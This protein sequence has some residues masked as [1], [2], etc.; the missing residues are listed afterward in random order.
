[1]PNR[2]PEAVRQR[3]RDLHRAVI[4]INDSLHVASVTIR[5]ESFALKSA[6][7]RIQQ[8]FDNLHEQRQTINDEIRQ[9]YAAL[10]I[11]YDELSEL[12]GMERAVAMAEKRMVEGK[13]KD[14]DLI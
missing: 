5:D 12:P 9:L 8:N 11:E 3:V 2:H 7:N 13:E 10:G 4:N 1:M 6:L 14:G